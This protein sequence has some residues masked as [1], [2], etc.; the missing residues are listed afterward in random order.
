[1]LLS[2]ACTVPDVKLSCLTLGKK[3]IK[4]WKYLQSPFQKCLQRAVMNTYSLQVSHLL[5]D[6]SIISIFSQKILQFLQRR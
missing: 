1:M 2:K 6:N 3:F 5:S 4:S